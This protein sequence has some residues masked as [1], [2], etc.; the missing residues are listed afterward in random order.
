[1]ALLNVDEKSEAT[2][3]NAFE[4]GTPSP[5]HCG[6]PITVKQS[7][8]AEAGK[9]VFVKKDA[10]AGELVFS[11]EHSLLIVVCFHFSFSKGE[12]NLEANILSSRVNGVKVKLT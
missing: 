10:A 5:V 6:V 2:H 3:S 1:L 9:G 8:I 7:K 12:K 4:K 11:V